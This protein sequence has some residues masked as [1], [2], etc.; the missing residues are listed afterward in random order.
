[1]LRSV[2]KQLRS[3]FNICCF[4]DYIIRLSFQWVLLPARCFTSLAGGNQVDDLPPALH[5]NCRAK[6]FAQIYALADFKSKICNT[7]AEL[8]KVNMSKV[9]VEV[10]N[11]LYILLGSVITAI[12]VVGFLVPNKIA[13]GGTIWSVCSKW[14]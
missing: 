8:K 10:Y 14:S 6:G 5:S 9:K 7:C 11:Y 13:T 1:M 3:F 4:R 2:Y 12:G